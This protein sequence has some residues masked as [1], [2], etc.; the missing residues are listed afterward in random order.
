MFSLF[1]YVC[2]LG[3]SQTLKPVTSREE[4][5]DEADRGGTDSSND[6]DVTLLDGVPTRYVPPEQRSRSPT[7]LPGS[8]LGKRLRDVKKPPN[9]IDVDSTES[10]VIVMHQSPSLAPAGEASS[11]KS[12]EGDIDVE[13]L[14]APPQAPAVELPKPPALPPRRPDISD[15]VIMF[16]MC[17]VSSWSG[18]LMWLMF[19]M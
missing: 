10:F 19:W 1:P 15:S 6:T 16:G 13:M 3:Y 18:R 4:E 8:I 5:E 14:T 12:Q 7:Q 17:D 11:S 9:G 2:L